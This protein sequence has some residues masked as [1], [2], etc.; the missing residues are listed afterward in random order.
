VAFDSSGEVKKNGAAKYAEKDAEISYEDQKAGRATKPY[1]G[2]GKDDLLRFSQTPFWKRLRMACLLTF[3]FAWLGLLTSVITL[4]VI[5]P[6]CKTEPENVW[7]QTGNLYQVYVRSFQDSDG[8]GVGDL[9]GLASRLDYLKSISTDAVILSSFYKGPGEGERDFGYEIVDHK[10]VDPVYGSLDDFDN[11]LKSAHE[12]DMKIIIDFVPNY[13]SD[14]HQWFVQ[15]RQTA[16]ITNPYWNYYVWTDCSEGNIPNNWKTVYGEPAWT[17]VPERDQCYLH[18]FQSSQP[19]LDLRSSAVQEEMKSILRFWLERGVDGFRVNVPSY[20]FE[21]T[22]L[23][24]DP[25]IPNCDR[26]NPYDCLEHDNTRHLPEVYD[27]LRRWNSVIKEYAE[28]TSKLFLTGSYQV[29]DNITSDHTYYGDFGQ[30]PVYYGL[31]NITDACDGFCVKSTVNKWIDNTYLLEDG[32]MWATASQDFSR[33]IH[34]RPVLQTMLAFTLPGTPVMYYGQELGMVDGAMTGTSYDP[35]GDKDLS[36][37][38][39]Q[40]RTPMQWDNTTFAGF[41]NSSDADPWLAVNEDYAQ[42]N[43]EA[44]SSAPLSTLSL[45][46]ALSLMRAHEKAFYIGDHHQAYYDEN[47]FSFVREFN[48]QD[49]FLV[50]MNFGPG[51]STVDYRDTQIRIPLKA[52]VFFSTTHDF[53]VGDEINLDALTISPGAGVILM[54]EY[55]R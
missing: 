3:W 4:T 16:N 46:K 12:K 37:S 1:A 23:T 9:N 19:E 51:S 48:G 30:L 47:I 52:T 55:S 53:T 43:V 2:M 35:R 29:N 22:D 14:Q 34:D 39:D 44:E 49:S 18:Q 33:D 31:R 24:N 21:N 6:R 27:M 38:R 40:Y 20:L 32:R 8:D 36:K 13:T 5:L 26:T 28:E 15:S 45:Y 41:T 54:W 11:L 7:W 50:A 25:I 10:D 42:V 17:F